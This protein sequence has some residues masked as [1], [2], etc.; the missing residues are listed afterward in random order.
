MGRSPS[1]NQIWCILALKYGIYDLVATIL[2]IFHKLFQPDKIT[3]KIE[4]SRII[5][6]SMAVR[7]VF[8]DWA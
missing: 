7:L 1:Q 8:L 5:L 3:T 4:R 6:S 2:M